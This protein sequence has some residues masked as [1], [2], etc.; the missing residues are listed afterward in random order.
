[1]TTAIHTAAPYRRTRVTGRG[2]AMA[3]TDRRT[4][5]PFRLRRGGKLIESPHQKFF[6]LHASHLPA[7]NDPPGMN[8]F[9][10][11]ACSPHR[12]QRRKATQGAM[13]V[14]CSI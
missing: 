14:V 4:S 2:A 5:K 12:R 1:M 10:H 11:G 9:F 6:S 7:Q 3:A 13:L 8:S